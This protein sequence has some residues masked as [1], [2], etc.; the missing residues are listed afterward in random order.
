MTKR[1]VRPL[2]LLVLAAALALPACAHDFTVENRETPVH[3]WLTAPDL[4]AQGGTIDVLIYVG[5]EKVIQGP[6]HFPA[7]VGHIVLPTVYV[8]AGPTVVSAVVRGGTAGTTKTVPVAG[9]TWLHVVVQGRTVLVNSYN[10]QPISA[11]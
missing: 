6:V 8:T 4:V 2:P 11:G 5:S 9:E 3:V 1:R 10:G 7:G